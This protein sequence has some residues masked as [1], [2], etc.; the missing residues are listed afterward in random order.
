M[1]M[2][3]LDEVELTGKRVFLRV[4]YN[5]PLDKQR[6]VKDDLRIRA[7]LP[8][9]RKILEA[10]GK[11]VL[12]SHLGRPKGKVAE[13]F[14]LKPVA[15]YL[16]RLLDRP[17]TMASDCLGKTVLE[18]ASAMQAGE[19]LLLENLRFHP[20]EEKNDDNFSRQLAELAEVYVNDAF[21]VS[22]R[23]HASVHGITRYVK[24]CAAGYQLQKEVEYFHKAMQEPRRPLAMVIGGAKIST[25]IDLLE[26]LVNQAD[27]LI[28][29]GAMA[30]TFLKAQGKAV[31]KSLVEDDHL[32]TAAR[33]LEKAGTRGIQ[34]L[35][36]VDAVVATSLE[37][38]TEAREVSIDQVPADNAIFDVGP[39]TVAAFETVLK[40][41]GTVV[42]NGPLGAFENPPFHRSTFALAGFLAQLDALTVIGGG[43]SAAAVREAGVAEKV[44]Y[45]STG[46]GA[47]LEMLEGKTLPGIA[48]L[49]EC[50]N[51][52]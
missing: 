49:E 51:Q 10:G 39:K 20:G 43:D 15:D 47:F 41:C 32:G 19:V 26:N 29:G 44:S 37:S 6:Q 7:T 22:H 35:L 18:Q 31:G 2:K 3:T 1:S 52:A 17:V 13:E 30:N 36:P 46:G 27:C 28:I 48:A 33:L 50:S 14:S 38:G 4:D 11:V 45:V 23:A 8:S 12:A 5:V 34:L 21:A 25:K 24:V 16:S 42:W 40:D 9:I